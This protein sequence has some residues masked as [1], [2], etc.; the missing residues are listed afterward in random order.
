METLIKWLD[1]IILWLM[2]GY[3]KDVPS[4]DSII[5][6]P[7][8][9]PKKTNR[10]TLYDTAYA[11]LGVDMAPL[12][13][14]LGCAE[15]LSHILIRAGVSLKSPIVS[16]YALDQWLQ[17]NLKEVMDPEAGDIISSPTGTG[18]GKIRGHVGIVGKNSIMSNNSQ[19]GKWDYHWTMKKWLDY[20]E[21]YGGIP[22][23]YY[24]W[25]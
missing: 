8:M 19:T 25:V 6:I 3:T 20:Y 5:E 14:T 13:D 21:K 22:T 17:K 2:R 23:K 11:S 24:R 1:K 18:N 16:S 12:N 15:A 10:E 4:T 9:P 7:I